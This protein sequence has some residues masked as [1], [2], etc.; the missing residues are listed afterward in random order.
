MGNRKF[1]QSN[2]SKHFSK[3]LWERCDKSIFGFLHKNSDF[4]E[5]S[6][7]KAFLRSFGFFFVYF[8]AMGHS[9]CHRMSKRRTLLIIFIVFSKRLICNA[10]TILRTLLR[11]TTKT[12][13]IEMRH[14]FKWTNIFKMSKW[15]QWYSNFR[16]HV[17]QNTSYLYVHLGLT[18]KSIE[19][20]A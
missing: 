19:L 13:T 2:I 6:H 5:R 9:Q 12:N 4:S 14:K 16:T 20:F 3:E 11:T 1:F 15:L 10:I 8:Q 17:L 18:P 7:W